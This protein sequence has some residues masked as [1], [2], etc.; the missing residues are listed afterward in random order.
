[1]K[2]KVLDSKMI[3]LVLQEVMVNQMDRLTMESMVPLPMM[4]TM[5]PLTLLLDKKHM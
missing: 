1:M 2:R 5:V 4:L 3:V